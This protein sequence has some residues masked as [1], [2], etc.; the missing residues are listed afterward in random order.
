MK[1]GMQNTVMHKYAHYL[2]E[3]EIHPDDDPEGLQKDIDAR[4]VPSPGE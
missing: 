1:R 3:M 4:N 2:F